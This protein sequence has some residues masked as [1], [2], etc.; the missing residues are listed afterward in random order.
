[1]ASW[2][3]MSPQPIR[4]TTS[5]RSM[6]TA[7]AA[8]QAHATV[9]GA[10]LKSSGA[11]GAE[12]RVAA[13][14]RSWTGR[15][16]PKK[17]ILLATVSAS[18]RM[19]DERISTVP[20]SGPALPRLRVVRYNP[21]RPTHAYPKP[22]RRRERTAMSPTAMLMLLALA[23]A[24]F[25][26]SASRRGRLLQVGQPANRL[27]HLATRLRGTWTFAFRQEK[28]DYYNAAGTAHT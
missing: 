21:R 2:L 17:S 26:W 9:R 16:R 10:R 23:W 6:S 19:G 24:I 25:L 15:G 13:A 5:S 4:S 3:L 22:W 7:L 18:H 14:N 20:A 11:G 27:D 12:R 8:R 1:M 28:M